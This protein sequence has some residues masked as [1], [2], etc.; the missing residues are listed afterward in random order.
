ML[1]YLNRYNLLNATVYEDVS[2]N[3]I[4]FSIVNYFLKVVKGEKIPESEFNAI[5]NYIDLL[6][7]ENTQRYNN[8]P[9]VLD[10]KD[11]YISKDQYIAICAFS[12]YHNLDYDKRFWN[13]VKFATYDNLSGKFNL[14]RLLSP[15]DYIYIGSLN[16]NLLCKLLKPLFYAFTWF[17]FIHDKKTRPTFWERLKSGFKLEPRTMFKTDGQ[18]LSFVRHMGFAEK[19]SF[20]DKFMWKML[21]KFCSKRYKNGFQS[22]LTH[23]YEI[24]HPNSMLAREISDYGV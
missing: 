10:G 17:S 23:Y 7:N 18:I 2:E 20:L 15:Q 3:C 1:T 13:G 9:G 6:W 12:H 4:L 16:E 21:M 22:I 11:A 8:I 5:K 14:V 19:K 24:T